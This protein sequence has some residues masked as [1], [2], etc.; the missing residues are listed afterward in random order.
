VKSQ[1]IEGSGQP[2]VT[3][4]LTGLQGQRID[5]RITVSNTGNVALTFSQFSDP[6]CDAGTI[7]GGPN[8]ALTPGQSTVYTCSHLITAQDQA[9][10]S[11]TNVAT[12]TGTPPNGPST[13]TP[14]NQV[15]VLV[16]APGLSILKQQRDA[17]TNSPAGYTTQ[18]ITGNVG[19]EIDYQMTVTNTGGVPLSISLDDPHCDAGT[20]AGPTQA[21]GTLNG[22]TLSPNSSANYTCHH[23]L[24]AGDR[25][26]FT[27]TAT[28]T[29][30][31]PGGPPV[32]TPPSSVVVNVPPPTIPPNPGMTVVKS[33]TVSGSGSAYTTTPV[34]ANPGQTVLYHMTVTNTGNEPLALSFSDPHCDAN[35]LSGPSGGLDANGDLAVGAQTVYSCSHLV[36][37][38]DAPAFTNVVTV[39]GTPPSGPPTGPLSS[40]VV[41]NIPSGGVSPAQIVSPGIK[42]AVGC[43]SKAFKAVITG[44]ASNVKSVTFLVDGKKVRTLT[45]VG[46]GNQWTLTVDP[47]KLRFGSHTVT[48]RV[49]LRK[50][51]TKVVTLHI[52]RCRAPKPRFTG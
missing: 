8:A 19:D 45:H 15:V 1:S 49:T 27:N 40:S 11:V 52:R 25:P 47:A 9:N 30:T 36:V 5:Y 3:S 12:V 16:P 18:T 41:A 26:S 21:T 46:A 33:Q 39:T 14:S 50:G 23:I 2:F 20:I 35:T 7:G 31:P 13:T 38:S 48:A 44:P 10:G 22:T 43:V 51:G 24:T 29:G 32:T 6:M 17:T 37:A 28:A 42:G 34:T 4:T